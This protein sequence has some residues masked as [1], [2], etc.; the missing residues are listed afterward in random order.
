MAVF[1]AVANSPES[2][3]IGKSFGQPATYL[4]AV[5]KGAV[6]GAAGAVVPMA[7]SGLWDPSVFEGRWE[8]VLGRF[9]KSAVSGAVSGAFN[10]IEDF[11]AAPML[12]GA[13]AARH[14]AS[15]GKDEVGQKAAFKEAAERVFA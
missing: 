5:V 4:D 6:S 3:I 10:E 15:E 9:G 11:K 8:D 7:V 13:E 14:A 2:G 12:A 1:G